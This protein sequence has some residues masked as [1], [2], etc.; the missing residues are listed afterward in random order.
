MEVWKN[1]I[2]LI[3]K[4]LSLSLTMFDKLLKE[5]NVESVNRRKLLNEILREKGR[6]SPMTN[7]HT[8]TQEAKNQS[9]DTTTPPK[10]SISQQLRSDLRPSV[11]VTITTPL[12]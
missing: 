12:V 9:D 8:L 3:G 4:R 1:C 10:T 11:G 2:D 7:T 5:Y 6:V